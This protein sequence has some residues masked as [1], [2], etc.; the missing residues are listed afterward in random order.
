MLIVV[1]IIGILAAAAVPKFVGSLTFHHV[2]SAARRVKADLEH[3]RQ[4]ARLTS[5]AQ[6]LT[7]TGSVYAADVTSDLRDLDARTGPY[8]VDLSASPYEIDSVV[9]DFNSSTTISFD[10]YGMPSDTGH[11]LLQSGAYQCTVQVEPS[12]E[13]W[14][15]SNP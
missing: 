7:F 2:E 4:T 9:A 15:H 10:G 6:A 13:V 5:R 12:G 3:V 14:I 11:V 8:S 1:T